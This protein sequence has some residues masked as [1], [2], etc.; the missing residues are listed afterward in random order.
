MASLPSRPS[1]VEID[2]EVGGPCS[3]LARAAPRRWRSR[4]ARPRRRPSAMNWVASSGLARA[5]GPGDQQAVALGDAAAQHRVERGD[6]RSRAAPG[7]AA[8][9]ASRRPARPGRGAREDLHPVAGDAEGVQARHGRLAAHLHDLQLA[10]D[11]VALDALVQ[12]EEAVGDGED[13]VVADLRLGVLADQ[14]GR[15]LPARQ[16]Q[17]QPLDEALRSSARSA[18]LPLSRTTVRNES[19]TTTPGVDGSRP[20]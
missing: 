2:A 1:A 5:R 4:P 19:T 6:A 16:V 13:R 3:V 7:S 10:H 18:G 9:R 17:R 11:R 12:P 8:W 14:E 20:P 15:R